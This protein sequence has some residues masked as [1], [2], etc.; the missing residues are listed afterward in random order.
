MPFTELPKDTK[1]FG[2]AD[3]EWLHLLVGDW[4]LISD[5]AFADLILSFPADYVPA[6]GSGSGRGMPAQGSPFRVLAH[7]RPAT[8]PTVFHKDMVGELLADEL[9]GPL[10][11]AW[12][13]RRIE[14]VR[15][16]GDRAGPA[17]QVKVVPLVRKGRTLAL[18]TLH[19][20]RAPGQVVSRQ[21]VVYRET[22]EVLLRMANEGL[23][24][25]FSA[26]TGSRR[27][28]PRVGDGAIRLDA[29]E[30]VTYVSPNAESALRRLGI[31]GELLGE[32][33]MDLVPPVLGP[34]ADA[35]ET[36]APVLS[37]R[38]AWRSEV[39]GA[40][41]SV[42]FRSVPLRDRSGRLGAVLL[43]RDVTELRRRDLELV[44]KDAT[45]REI[46]HRVKNNL[47]TVSAL[48]RLQARRMTTDEARHGLE[49]AMR[50][51][52]TI[53]MVH[54]TLSQGFSQ[55]VD[56]DELVARQ[57]RLAA[58]VASPEQTVRTRMIG[59][60]GELPTRL[61]TPL[62][63]VIN[64]L[65]TNAVEHGLAGRTGTVTLEAA[66]MEDEE[67]AGQ[68]L[69]VVVSDDGAGM[70]D[71]V[72]EESGAGAFRRAGAGEGLGMQIV[73]TLVAGEL[74]GWIRWVP[75]QDGGTQ[76]TVCARVD[77]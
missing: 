7:V 23:W 24:P 20:G 67:G 43:C 34:G 48:L 26:P 11:A 53:A 77:E 72:I 71:V 61:A 33:L 52:A 9:A 6:A 37:G 40:R 36:L 50:R 44:S 28:A 2:P 5:L 14:P 1:D 63:L 21:E 49:Q 15:P 19:A 41:V 69:E 60:F 38:T 56:F 35:D 39:E 12:V 62:A 13:G 75:R 31:D 42:N 46:H 66:R 16:A 27:G 47:Q 30:R 25:D 45:V 55:N 3:H 73:R 68:L 10:R 57:F 54:E 70:G 58:E 8:G 59:E 51:V 32:R 17:A 29:E 18:L 74:G 76:V 22:A 64:E 4:Q 65:V